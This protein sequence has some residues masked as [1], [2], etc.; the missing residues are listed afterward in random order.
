MKVFIVFLA[1]MFV[2]VN[3]MIFQNDMSV[4]KSA[5]NSLKE[6]AEDCAY[7]AS[8]YTDD[9]SYADGYLKFDCESGIQYI[10]DRIDEY[11]KK[12]GRRRM[13]KISYTVYFFD[14]YGLCA[15]YKD[16]VRSGEIN[17]ISYPYSFTS[18]SGHSEVISEPCVKVEISADT[19]GAFRQEF[20]STGAT[21]RSSAYG[22]RP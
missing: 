21:V 16:G 3:M 19:S 17:G 7:A 14:E 5:Q 10:E 18:F 2:N 20:I 12:S 11:R 6:A 15:I 4:Y 9:A 13:D 1:L 8:L 22:A